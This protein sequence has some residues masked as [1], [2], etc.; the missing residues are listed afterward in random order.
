MRV[1]ILNV[2]TYFYD[3]AFRYM[4]I[5][6]RFVLIPIYVY[7]TIKIINE[8]TPNFHLRINPIGKMSLKN[9]CSMGKLTKSQDSSFDSLSK[10]IFIF[11]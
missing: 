4:R 3:F 1:Y 10:L 6:I 5:F 8:L 11:S 2:L 9:D 7:Y